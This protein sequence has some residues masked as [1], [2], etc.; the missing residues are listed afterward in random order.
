M[1]G[2]VYGLPPLINWRENKMRNFKLNSK[3]YKARGFSFNTVCDLE[4]IGVSLE[5]MQ[6]KPMSMIRAY[7]SICLDT[8][9]E[10]AGKEIEGHIVSGGNFDE[11]MK[12]ITGEMNDSDFFQNLSKKEEE[13]I[14]E[15]QEEK[16]TE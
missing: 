11:I 12:V 3:E 5:D 6:K 8:S 14:G 10:L 7:L 13:E 9:L 16:K 4:D 15:N 1:S 2:A